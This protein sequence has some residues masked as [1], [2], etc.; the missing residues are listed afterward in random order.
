MTNQEQI[1]KNLTKAVKMIAVY[2]DDDRQKFCKAISYTLSKPQ[3]EPK[4]CKHEH[5]D[6][7]ENG[8]GGISKIECKDCKKVLVDVNKKPEEEEKAEEKKWVPKDTVR[9]FFVTDAGY[10]G[11]SV[12][13]KNKI[14]IFRQKTNNLFR[15]EEE[16][17]EKLKEILTK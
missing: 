5:C 15:T 10:V 6:I 1:N 3:V 9:Y 14:D 17:E 11:R 16:A 2:V 13:I 4:E 12:F 7:Q 8:N